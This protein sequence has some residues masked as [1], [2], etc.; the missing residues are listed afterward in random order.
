MHNV[1]NFKVHCKKKFGKTETSLFVFP[2][3]LFS[4]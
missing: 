4:M 3:T 2:F 1:A